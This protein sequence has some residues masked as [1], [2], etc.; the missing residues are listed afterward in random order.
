M[1]WIESS[2]RRYACWLAGAAV[3]GGLAGA[4]PARAVPSMARQTGMQ[5]SA[6][7]TVFPELTPFGRQFK[8]RGFTMGTALKDRR[9]PANLPLAGVVQVSNTR[10]DTRAPTATEALER[11]RETI[12]QATGFYYGGKITDR[13][14]ALVQYTYD[15]VERATAVE[16]VD[17]RFADEATLG[18]RGLVYGVTLNNAPTLADIYNSTPMW[19]FPHVEAAGAMVPAAL[20]D[21]ELAAQVGG[22][23]AY[24][25]WNDRVYVEIAGYRTAARGLLRPLH[26]GVPIERRVEGTAPYWRVA[27]QHEAGIH[28]A[29]VGTFGLIAK[30]RPE[31][32]TAG[33]GTDRY[34]DF[35]LDAQYQYLAEPVSFTTT[36]AWI[37]ERQSLRASAA[38]GEADRPR[39]TLRSFR[40]NAHVTYR[41]RVALGLGYFS[42]D[43]G[44]DAARFDTGEP[45]EGSVRARPDTRGGLAELALLPRQDL[46]LVV[47][48]T[49]F[50]RYNGARRDYDG[51]GRD[52]ADNDS[53]YLLAWWAL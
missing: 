24:A 11:D 33:T 51:F 43:G 46:K 12:A 27:W 4:E 30:L 17:V 53:W 23:G 37:D 35:G 49:V 32:A 38:L 41:R 40:W 45:F 39:G 36:A 42:V 3:V 48:R 52:A 50:T 5:C 29:A 34:R 8:L 7:H 10:T 15:G 14:G 26:A 44:P 20:V 6:C 19:A 18:G 47:R 9:F 31:D 1:Q 22:L 2:R 13:I 21:M 28:S 25:M 16:M